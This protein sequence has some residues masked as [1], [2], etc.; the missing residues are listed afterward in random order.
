[1][2]DIIHNGRDLALLALTPF[3]ELNVDDDFVSQLKG[4]YSSCNYFLME[5]LVGGRDS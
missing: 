2:S 3:Y 5:I 4:A 1:M